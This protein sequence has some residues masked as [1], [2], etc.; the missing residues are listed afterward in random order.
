MKVDQIVDGI[1]EG[2]PTAVARAI[3][4]VERG[5]PSAEQ[6][7]EQLY[8]LSGGAHVVGITGIPGSGKSTLVA[9]LAQELRDRDRTVGVVAIDPS[10]PYSGGSILGDRVR[11]SALGGDPGIF[12]RSMATHG[13]LG[14]LARATADAVTVLDAAGMDTVLIETVG[15]GQDEVE[16][17]AASHSTVVV[18]VPGTGDD[19]QA[20]KA[21]VLEIADLHVVN[22]ADRDGAHR[23][24][25]Q[26]K[27][28]L[29]LAGLREGEGVWHVPVHDT[30]AEQGT[31]VGELLDILDDHR[32]WLHT[33]D[34]LRGREL[35]MGETRVR[36]IVLD[37]VRQRMDAALGDRIAEDIVVEVS[38]RR[39]TP[40]SAARTLLNEVTGWDA[41][42]VKGAR[43]EPAT[44]R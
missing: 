2:V 44:S 5:R 25:G 41:Q 27:D 31:G 38:E 35:L 22:K 36:A 42:D 21:G 29:R 4:M 39:R 15:V 8:P 14:G 43:Y 10:S 37:L 20:I 33:S 1:R 40:L 19:I 16:I 12:V 23:L 9:R 11:M 17:A 24:V 13:A 6:L 7:M 30:V 32:G 18:S 34:S 28:M 26:L 3:S